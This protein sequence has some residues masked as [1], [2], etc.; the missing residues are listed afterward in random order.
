MKNP[1][2]LP[3]RLAVSA[4]EAA[5]ALG[6][7]G[8]RLELLDVNSAKLELIRSRL[9]DEGLKVSARRFLSWTHSDISEL[10]SNFFEVQSNL[11]KAAL[12]VSVVP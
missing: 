9:I 12:F 11:N 2:Q 5:M 4:L 3:V 8:A 1:L 6:A 7:C 10:R